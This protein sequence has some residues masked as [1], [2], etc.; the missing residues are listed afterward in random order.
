MFF[1]ILLWFYIN[2]RIEIRHTQHLSLLHCFVA[3]CSGLCVPYLGH[4]GAVSE[5]KLC[6]TLQLKI[7]RNELHRYVEF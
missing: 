2:T 5:A 3:V 6:V 4:T 1:C 7:H